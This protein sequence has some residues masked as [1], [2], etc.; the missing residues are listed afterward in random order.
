M[1][2]LYARI[3]CEGPH[4]IVP[5]VRLRL[6]QNTAVAATSPPLD[7]VFGPVSNDH[8]I[9]GVRMAFFFCCYLKKGFSVRV[10]F[11][12]SRLILIRTSH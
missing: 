11:S 2:V 7:Y 9:P 3:E 8:G 4:R 1:S 10:F 6:L 5:R 12:R